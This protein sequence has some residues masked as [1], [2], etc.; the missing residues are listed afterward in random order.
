MN[1]KARTTIGLLL[2]IAL[3]IGACQ[4][5]TG[6]SGEQL[7]KAKSESEDTSLTPEEQYALGVAYYEGIGVT[8][9]FTQSAHWFRKA[10][11][12]G[13]AGAQY[14]LGAAYS[15]GKGVEE[16]WT[17]AYAWAI[18]AQATGGE[19]EGNET[20]REF[21]NIIESGLSPTEIERGQQRAKE[22]HEQIQANIAERDQAN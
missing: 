17:E 12:Q 16:D 9:D 3:V 19:T 22:L 5:A 7:A 4:Q 20:L 2:L 8:K 10:A 18:I 15:D 14:R 21:T 1:R 11:E 13:H 6:Q